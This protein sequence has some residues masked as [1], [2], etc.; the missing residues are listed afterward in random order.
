MSRRDN[1][2]LRCARCQM[3]GALC[4]CPLIPEPPLATRTKLVL[5]IH[6]YE[7]RKP[8]NTGQLAAAG[9]A[10]SEVRIR[11]RK[12]GASPPFEA[13]PGTR[14]LLLFPDDDATPLDRLPPSDEPVTLIVPDGTW[15]QAQ[16]VRNRVPGLRQV[17]C[18]TLPAGG[19]PSLYRLRT[20]IR[21]GG[22]ATMEAIMRAFALLEGPHV[23]PPMERVFR[24]MVERTL[25]SRGTLAAT[26][27]ADG[28]PEGALREARGATVAEP[29][30]LP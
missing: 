27:V 13:A 12:E 1:A 2:D 23:L 25:W 21:D 11:G 29:A 22:L 3:L 30:A 7:A 19:P 18:V 26:D 6:R 20:E 24:A 14:P 16:R 15:R 9:L 17:P 5:Y 10:G 8:T 4:V 28:I